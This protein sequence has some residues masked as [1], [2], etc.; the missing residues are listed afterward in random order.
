MKA[1][2]PN[3]F[4]GGNKT[5]YCPTVM[6]WHKARGTF[7]P[8]SD[9]RAGDLVF[10]DW[11]GNGVADHIG[12]VESYRGGGL[13]NTIEGNTTGASYG[14]FV[15]RKQRSL[16]N[17][18]GY[19]R[20]AYGA[21]GAAGQ[22]AAAGASAG[23]AAGR[24]GSTWDGD[25]A[26]GV[27][28]T[29]T[30]RG[31]QFLT[32]ERV[33]SETG[34]RGDNRAIMV[35]D[36]GED[37]SV[38]IANKGKYYSPRVLDGL[39]WESELYGTPG[40]LKFTVLKDKVMEDMGGFDE[41]APVRV[42]KKGVDVF[43]GYVFKKSRKNVDT[44]EVTAYDQ[45]RYLKTKDTYVFANMTATQI[46]KKLASDF[47]LNIGKLEDTA[48]AFESRIEDG[49][50]LFDMIQGALDDTLVATKKMYVLYDDMGQLCLKNIE[51][52]KTDLVIDVDVIPSF[53]YSS[54]ID[55]DTYNA[56]KLT[57]N[58]TETSTRDLYIAQDAETQ[59]RWGLLQYTE[60]LEDPSV[61][62]QKAND[63]LGMLNRKTR[64]LSIP[65]TFGRADIRAG[66]A[67]AVKLN[68]GDT[69]LQNYLVVKRVVHKVTENVHT[70]TLTLIGG[71]F[72]A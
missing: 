46:V 65:D 13:V 22:G 56:I 29:D 3:L 52:M 28:D 39:T 14:D 17:I 64:T 71:E 50:T 54:S 5:A 27:A 25:T 72:V 15:A 53:N 43:Y 8:K 2:A 55:D 7:H 20:P 35:G 48:H 51:S 45:L 67:V 26:D 63:L 23:A 33:V 40:K 32:E 37:V 24:S 68:L 16:Y 10:F 36:T 34:S 57:Y 42:T 21:S 1:R 6:N 30:A 41:G 70:M 9:P 38:I 47:R 4:N 60:K 61:G 66:C 62:V 19:G 31:D 58:N 44:I 12:I 59:K 49:S 11:T 18:L 69:V